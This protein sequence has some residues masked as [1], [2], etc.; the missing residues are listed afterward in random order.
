MADLELKPYL[1]SFSVT[2]RCDLSCPHCFMDAGSSQEELGFEEIERILTEVARF[3]PY[4]MLILTGGEPLLRKDIYSLVELASRLGFVTV[5]GTSGRF[6]SR[7]AA[8]RLSERGLKGVSVSVDS[9]SPG[10]HDSFRGSPG[11]WERALEALR[12]SRELGI[13]TQM[14]VTLTDRNA[15]QVEELVELGV[16]LRVRAVNF[17]FIVC[18][19]RAA[20]SFISVETYGE[21]LRRIAELSLREK[22]LIVRAR[23]APHAFRFFPQEGIPVGG[24]TRGC[25]A[26][27]F[28]VRIDHQGVLY[29]CPYLPVS[30]GSL[31]ESTFETLWRNS[32]LLLRLRGE[33]Y[34]GRCGVCRYRLI[35]G[36]CRARALTETGNL[37][38]SDPLCDYEP[39]AS[40]DPLPPPEPEK[41]GAELRWT[42][43]ALERIERIPF[44]LKRIIVS[45][46]ERRAR[47]EGLDTVTPEFLERVRRAFHDG[48]S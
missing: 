8:E 35:C 1:I 6:L 48:D 47:E 36:G 29:P 5:L 11:S 28:Y 7:D 31:R 44:F 37:M 25:P 38:G 20:R 3:S 4:S 17:F 18:T 40:E 34:E 10:Y 21:L 13:D 19:G 14:N 46:I 45:L 32:P 9:V 24:G 33:D 30:A 41:D 15:D 23:C 39:V 27:R 2:A 22:R 43:E 26:G 42:P 12:I 16:E